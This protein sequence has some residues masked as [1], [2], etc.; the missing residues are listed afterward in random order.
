MSSPAP[1]DGKIIETGYS[2]QCCGCLNYTF[3]GTCK[4]FPKQI[5]DE[6]FTGLFD[7]AEPYPDAKNPTDHGIRYDPVIDE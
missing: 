2:A 6:I 4:A 5:P 7:H 1:G 3:F